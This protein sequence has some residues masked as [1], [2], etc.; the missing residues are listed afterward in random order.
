MKRWVIV[1]L[2]VQAALI[3]AIALVLYFVP[4]HLQW[5]DEPTVQAPSTPETQTDSQNEA[6]D[7][8]ASQQAER[9]GSPMNKE[10]EEVFDARWAEAPENVRTVARGIRDGLAPDPSTLAE[11]GADALSRGYPAT[12]LDFTRNGKP[13]A[14]L[15]T[16]LQDA[17]L[18]Y[19]FATTR[20][21]L[22]AGAQPSANNGEILF[23]A[24]D[25]T[26]R[27]APAFALFPDIDEM[28]PFL[29]AYLETPNNP[30]VQR[31]GFL[32]ETA[33]KNAT[34]RNNLG[35]MLILLEHGAD[36]WTTSANERGYVP[37]STMESLAFSSGNAA[38]A[39]KLFRIARSGYLKPGPSDQEDAVFAKL[40]SVAEKFA[41][42]TG[43][44]A[45]HTAWRLDQVLT[46]LGAALNREQDADAI[47]Q[48][49]TPFDYQA[50]GGWY[51]A[52]DEVH[53]RHDALLSVPD[54][55]S[56]IWG[57]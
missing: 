2:V 30:D 43:P 44:N 53:S 40:S 17:A 11:I 55:G 7:T 25:Q 24:V 47:R 41:T 46:V 42:G 31:H 39:E 8:V 45:R 16:L 56:E 21:L 19:D 38:T 1:A 49:L 29:L 3:V 52:E 15:S 33:L 57:P 48:T 35:A 18:A 51:L 14:Y 28:L 34:F 50:D 10:N 22:D 23:I 32:Q 4:V 9:T 37:D 6:G 13:V 20:A 5:V 27:G 12:T 54:K 36:P 26:T